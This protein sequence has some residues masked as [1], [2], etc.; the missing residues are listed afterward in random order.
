MP[1]FIQDFIIV[2]FALP[3]LLGRDAGRNPLFQQAIP[4]PIRVITSI[5]QKMLGRREIIQKLSGA[6]VVRH[7][8]RRQV[9]KHRFAR[10]ITN[11]VQ[12]RV[13][14]TFCAPDIAG[15]IPFFKRLQ[16]VR[17]AF[18]CVASICNCSGTS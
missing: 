5:C 7:L 11:R 17:C 2:N 9:H 6:L 8:T 13:Q 15:N 12:F 4:E 10:T 14:P 18:R 3:V 1:L 16:A